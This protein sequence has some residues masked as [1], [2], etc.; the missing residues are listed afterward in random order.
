MGL[1]RLRSWMV[2][3]WPSDLGH[4][5]QV[6]SQSESSLPT[7]IFQAWALV[8][9]PSICRRMQKLTTYVI[10]EKKNCRV[11]KQIPLPPYHLVEWPRASHIIDLSLGFPTCKRLALELGISP[12]QV[13]QTMMKIELKSLIFMWGRKSMSIPISKVAVPC[14]NMA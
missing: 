3:M 1:I 11:R 14:G 2:T 4:M 9:K 5:T 6:A 8:N 10:G 7:S 13:L 12:T